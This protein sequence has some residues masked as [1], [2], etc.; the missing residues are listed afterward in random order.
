MNFKT[1]ANCLSVPEKL[2]MSHTIIPCYKKD[3]ISHFGII[4]SYIPDVQVKV[5]A[6][7]LKYQGQCSATMCVTPKPFPYS[8]PAGTQHVPASDG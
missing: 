1:Y 5:Q 8:G 6:A 4:G 7:Y 3:F 2:E